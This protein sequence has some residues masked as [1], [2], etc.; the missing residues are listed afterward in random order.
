LP[1]RYPS[2]IALAAKARGFLSH[3][4]GQS[5]MNRLHSLL[6]CLALM[7][8]LAALAEP[9]AQLRIVP[10]QIRL[11]HALV[12]A[13]P[14][15]PEPVDLEALRSGP[16]LPLGLPLYFSFGQGGCLAGVHDE[17]GLS[18]LRFDCRAKAS[19][20]GLAELL[21]ELDP[22]LSED[23]IAAELRQ[24]QIWVMVPSMVR[25]SCRPCE[26]APARAQAI[27]DQYA[28]DAKVREVDMVF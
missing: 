25:G 11:M 28:P 5:S 10:E 22:R 17:Q 7:C 6:L 23:G 19:V 1:H 9:M 15:A 4:V 18:E 27:A 20:W 16:P 21:R 3:K 2:L 26:D 24:P 12:A 8:P 14:D 13:G